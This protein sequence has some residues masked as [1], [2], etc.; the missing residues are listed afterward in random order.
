MEPF[1]FYY[2]KIHPMNWVYLSS[3]LTIA[4]YFKFNRLWSLRNLDLV[5]LLLF[6]P[7][8]VFYEYGRNFPESSATY[9]GFIWLFAVGAIFLVRLL[10][11]S[12]MV[13]RPLLDPNMSFGGM[14]F[15]GGALLLFLMTNVANSTLEEINPPLDVHPTGVSTSGTEPPL[16][17]IER[18]GPRY[19]LLDLLPAIPTQK[20]FELSSSSRRDYELARS[21]RKREYAAK[22]IVILSH[23]AVVTGLIFIGYR[24]FDNARTGM[25]AAVLYL[26][27]PYTAAMTGFADH[28]LPAA[29]LVWAIASYRRPMIAGL[30]MGLAIG[31]IYY[32][33]FLLPLWISF[34][35]QRGLSRFCIGVVV[36]VAILAGVLV[37]AYYDDVDFLLAGLQQMFGLVEPEMENVEGFWAMDRIAPIWRVPVM[38][39]IIILGASFALWPAQKN[40]GTLMSCTAAMMLGMQFWHAH[41]GGLYMA[42]YMPMLLLTMFRPNLEDRVALSVL[43]SKRDRQRSP[44]GDAS[45]E[46]AA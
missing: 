25:A 2:K 30:F 36:T 44:G 8:L 22:A 20:F 33:V 5:C 43:S 27:I 10:I 46:K 29:L 26:L 12:L 17:G 31:V 6:A 35:W 41:N 9:T 1:L 7:G 15:L 19:P 14:T 34:Y 16:A 32:P 4:L 28:V 13:R 21:D 39:L 23:L 45:A 18:F 38:A 24:H 11:D 37:V 3:L 42:W 40:L